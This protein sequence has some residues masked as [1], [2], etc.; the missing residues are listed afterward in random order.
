LVQ[1]QLSKP[2]IAETRAGGKGEP[3]HQEAEGSSG[4]E[5]SEAFRNEGQS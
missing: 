3:I 1:K 5:S 4:Q 2:E